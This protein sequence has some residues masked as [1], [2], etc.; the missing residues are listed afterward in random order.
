MGCVHHQHIQK[1]EYRWID[2]V[3]PDPL[4]TKLPVVK[5]NPPG[6]SFEVRP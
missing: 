6:N 1:S 3:N 2:Y 5:F 4:V